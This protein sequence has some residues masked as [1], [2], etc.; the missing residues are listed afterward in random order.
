MG[1]AYDPDQ[2]KAFKQKHASFKEER[3]PTAILLSIANTHSW[4][5]EDVR[6][7]SELPVD[8][9]YAIFKPARGMDKRKIISAC[10]QFGTFMNAD[11]TMNEVS[12]KAREA[13][14]RIGQESAINA[15]R[16]KAYGVEVAPTPPKAE[17]G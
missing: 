5:P 16:V 11:A 10:L 15:P 8:E 9:Y 17:S 2:A 1:E 12:R 4:N 13:L 14:L 7:L 3:N 6:A